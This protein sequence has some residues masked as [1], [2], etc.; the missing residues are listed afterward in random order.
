MADDDWLLGAFP[1]W[2]CADVEVVAQILPAAEIAPHGSFNAIV[3]G[4]PVTIP[5]RIYNRLPE[6]AACSGLSGRERLI[7]HC[8]YSRHHDGHLRERCC[9]QL[10]LAGDEWVAPYVVHLLGEPVIEIATLIRDGL[11][12]PAEIAEP[13]VRFARSNGRLLAQTHQRAVS[14]WD[15]YYRERCPREEYP[16]VAVLQ[17]LMAA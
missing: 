10:L 16:A 14:Y 11:L 17:A 4:E 9:R 5:Y 8:I 15:A 1:S 6:A 13:F 3:G 7:A 12:D 2:L